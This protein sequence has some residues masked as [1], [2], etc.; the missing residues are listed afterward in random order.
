MDI[1]KIESDYF[2]PRIGNQGRIY[3]I[4]PQDTVEEYTEIKTLDNV[5]RQI[6]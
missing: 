3:Q 4:S 6:V 5:K 2:S 1:N